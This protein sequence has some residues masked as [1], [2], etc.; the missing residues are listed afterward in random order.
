MTKFTLFDEIEQDGSECH[1]FDHPTHSYEAYVREYISTDYE[2]IK[3][4]Y[5]DNKHHAL[6]RKEVKK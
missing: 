4:M 1:V 2:P 6:F 5:G 3:L